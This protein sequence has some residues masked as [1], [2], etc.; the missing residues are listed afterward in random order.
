VRNRLT[1]L[2]D[3]KGSAV[4][5]ED[6]FDNL[7]FAV[8]LRNEVPSLCDFICPD[9]ADD[10][11]HLPEICDYA[12][13][14]TPE[15]Q[16]HPNVAKYAAAA[17]KCLS[18]PSGII[19]QRLARC[20]WFMEHI[21]SLFAE[22]TI[23]TNPVYAGHLQAIVVSVVRRNQDQNLL[24]GPFCQM[25]SLVLEHIDLPGWQEGLQSLAVDWADQ[26]GSNL[27]WGDEHP[28]FLA[29]RVLAACANDFASELAWPAESDRAQRRLYGLFSTLLRVLGDRELEYSTFF[30]VDLAVIDGFIQAIIK[31]AIFGGAEAA[32]LLGVRVLKRMIRCARLSQD[33]PDFAA[34][35]IL[36]RKLVKRAAI[37]FYA[38]QLVKDPAKPVEDDD[39]W[40]EV[41]AFG[42]LDDKKK[43]ILVDVF[44]VFWQGGI[45]HLFPLFFQ[46]PA[47]SSLFNRTVVKHLARMSAANPDKF[48]VFVRKVGAIPLILRTW[49][50]SMSP[51][52]REM[53]DA[54][55]PKLILNPQVLQFTQ[56]ITYGRAK[57]PRPRRP[58]DDPY[59]PL[60]PP[61]QV[62]PLWWDKSHIPHYKDYSMWVRD[63][64]FPFYTFMVRELSERM[65][66]A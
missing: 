32:L 9:R 42:P 27:I 66:D 29:Y 57:W 39:R 40:H 22:E 51:L 23:I 50:K 46:N 34:N 3:S 35:S 6:V 61:E 54:L 8:S 25:F 31:A 7:D 47:V 20:T 4:T 21:Q 11:G 13:H 59:G 26:F 56:L 16:G 14:P 55:S 10:R 36:V 38:M 41:T 63:V 28:Q 15:Q 5:V 58:P 43:R 65:R 52:D 30:C 62:L 18:S 24:E 60:L 19:G 1:A 37:G 48:I 53:R 64:L 2:F 44:P 33:K 49:V 45:E 17:T 12:L